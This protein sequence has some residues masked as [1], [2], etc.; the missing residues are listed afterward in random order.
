LKNK[1]TALI[2]I[3]F[4]FAL[5]MAVLVANTFGSAY[6]SFTDVFKMLLNKLVFIHFNQTWQPADETIIFDI[7]LPRVLG[8]ALVGAAL[9]TAG[10]LFQGLLRNPMADPYI[11]GTSA[12]AALGATIAMLLPINLVMLGF[13]FVPI[14]AF[15]GALITVFIVYNLSRLGSRTPIVTML[16]AGV[17]VSAILTAVTFFLITFSD[18]LNINLHSVYSF[19]M[20]RVSVTSWGQIL[21][22]TPIVVG[23]I[24]G[25]RLLALRL[26]AF[27]MGEEGA[28]YVGVEVEHDKILILAL[29]SL[30]TAS[31]VSISGLIG[32]V[33]L[34]IPHAMRL[35]IGPDNRVLIPFSALAGAIFLIV[36]DLLARTVIS[37]SEIPVGIITAV[38]GG[39]FFLYLLRRNRKQYAF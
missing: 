19:L 22:A 17:V 29:G 21:V 3:I 2:F 35:I 1:K 13:G 12:G 16:L 20:G 33:G 5:I 37:P 7:R 30:L 24:I 26:N 39:P 6:V 18:Q 34:V 32:F 38:I 8:G 27:A 4:I 31:A 25:T 15:I 23:G 9:A 14:L 28:A 10:A 36:T 11:I